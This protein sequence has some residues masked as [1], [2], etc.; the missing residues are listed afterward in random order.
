MGRPIGIYA[1]SASRRQRAWAR[2]RRRARI[3]VARLGVLP[4]TATTAG[5]IALLLGRGL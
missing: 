2:R 4:L 5:A 3:A 1:S